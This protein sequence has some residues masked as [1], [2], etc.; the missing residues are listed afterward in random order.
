MI[1]DA[2][3]IGYPLF[4]KPANLGSSIGINKAADRESFIAAMDTATSFDRR[5]LIEKG[6]DSP[7]EINCA[8]LGFDGEAIP[9][10]CEQP[11]SWTEFLSFEDKYT[12]N[13]ASKGMKSLA[14]VIPAPIPDEMTKRI[15]E[16]TVK[17]FRMFECKGVV[18]MDYMIDNATGEVYAGEINT[19]PGSFAFYLFEPTGI[20]FREL[21]DKIVGYAYRALDQKRESTFA[22]AS[23][24]LDRA[25]AGI[26]AGGK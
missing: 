9:S 4:I 18:R 25:K 22:Y 23:D 26:K 13:G 7:T 14:R 3:K 17:I 8:C 12:R 24:I 19:I 11:K 20:S 10:L 6:L 21:L 1:E 5:V 16:Y 2:E 15:Q